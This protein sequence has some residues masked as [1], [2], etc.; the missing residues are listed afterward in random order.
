ML[1]GRLC[2]S[3]RCVLG[4]PRCSESRINLASADLDALSLYDLSTERF[5]IFDALSLLLPFCRYIVVL[6]FSCN[7]KHTLSKWVSTTARYGCSWL[8]TD[9][10]NV[11]GVAEFQERTKDSLPM[12]TETN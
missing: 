12:N 4:E 6:S 5:R 1:I 11:I 9:M 8:S 7:S 3:E 2:W 10:Y